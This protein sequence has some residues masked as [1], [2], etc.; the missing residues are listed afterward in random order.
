MTFEL[1][2]MGGGFINE[3]SCAS[4]TKTIHEAAHDKPTAKTWT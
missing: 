1:S 2:K 3:K 4:L